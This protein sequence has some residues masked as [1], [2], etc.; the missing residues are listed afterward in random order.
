MA[1]TLKMDLINTIVALSDRGW[2]KRRIARELDLDRQTVRRYLAEH[3]KSPPISTPG[4]EAAPVQNHPFSTPG[5][6]ASAKADNPVSSLGDLVVNQAIERSYGKAGRPSK[7]SPHA[8]FI[9]AKVEQ[10]LSAQRIYQDLVS[11]LQFAGSYQAVK[12]FI[13]QFKASTPTPIYRIEV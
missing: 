6:P 9:E 11:E 3:S 1:N 12:R 7:C 2:S 5:S 10:G 13:R 4:S 8:A